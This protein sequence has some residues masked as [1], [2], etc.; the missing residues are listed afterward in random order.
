MWS[1]FGKR[2]RM[3]DTHRE[4]HHGLIKPGCDWGADVRELRAPALRHHLSTHRAG[5]SRARTAG[6]CSG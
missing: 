3:P 4:Q 6:S 5:A 1:T 2:C